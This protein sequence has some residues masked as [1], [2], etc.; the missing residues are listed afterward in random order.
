[1]YSHVQEG[2]VHCLAVVEWSNICLKLS[3]AKCWPS[4]LTASLVTLA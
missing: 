2:T 1:M 4:Y 3:K